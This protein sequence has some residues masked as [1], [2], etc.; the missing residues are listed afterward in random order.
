MQEKGQK[1]VFQA[2]RAIN[3]Y[4][5]ILQACSAIIEPSFKV[6]ENESAEMNRAIFYNLLPKFLFRPVIDINCS[7]MGVVELN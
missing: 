2:V 1:K 4:L 5:V 6:A 7:S 3:W